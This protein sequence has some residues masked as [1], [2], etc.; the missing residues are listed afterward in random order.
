M[1]SIE[2]SRRAP[3]AS[4]WCA[5]PRAYWPSTVRRMVTCRVAGLRCRN[6]APSEPDVTIARH[7]AQASA[8]WHPPAAR[9]IRPCNRFTTAS[10]EEQSISDLAAAVARWSVRFAP[11]NVSSNPNRSKAS[12]P[13]RPWRKSAPFR[14]GYPLV[15]EALS[16]PLRG[17]LRLLRRSSTPSAMPFLAV[18]IP[19]CPANLLVRRGGAGGAYPVVQ[20]RDA[21]GAAASYSPAG[22]VATV[23][24]GSNRRA[25]PHAILAPACQHLWPVLDDGPSTDVHLRSAYHPLLGRLRICASRLWPLSPELHTSDC[26]FACPGSSTWVDKAPSRDT[27]SLNLAGWRGGVNPANPQVAQNQ[28]STCSA[29]GVTSSVKERTSSPPSVRNVT[30][31]LACSPWLF[32]TSNNR[33]LGF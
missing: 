20:C 11:S 4:S 31:W 1:L 16:A 27:P 28:S 18:G 22:R 21:N 19:P 33:R 25:D 3:S 29:S 8:A 32:S 5:T 15:A 12:Q 23:V 13:L 17:G 2:A 7:P 30:S 26:S 24:E 9:Q 6:P 10:A 14:A